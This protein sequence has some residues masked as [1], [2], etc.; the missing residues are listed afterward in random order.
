MRHRDGKDRSGPSSYVPLNVLI[1][2]NV[3]VYRRQLRWSVRRLARGARLDK[4]TILRLEAGS[5]D[6][7]MQTLGDNSPA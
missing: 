4:S 3:R 1:G 2:W 7:R 6:I 5:I